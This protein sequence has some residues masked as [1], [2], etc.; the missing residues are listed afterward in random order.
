MWCVNFRSSA[1]LLASAMR[2]HQQGPFDPRIHALKLVSHL[3]LVLIQIV[4]DCAQRLGIVIAIGVR[5]QGN[6]RGP[7][8]QYRER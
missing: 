6:S 7:S 4:D 8:V 1:S 5:E 2:S 3:I